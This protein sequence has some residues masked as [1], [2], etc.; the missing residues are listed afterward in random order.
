MRD[1][2]RVYLQRAGVFFDNPGRF[3]LRHQVYDFFE[4]DLLSIMRHA[5][6]LGLT[7]TNIHSATSASTSTSSLQ[8]LSSSS[9][10]TNPDWCGIET[11]R[12]MNIRNLDLCTHAI[13]ETVPTVVKGDEARQRLLSV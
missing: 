7:P 5:L 12:E 13:I 3:H 1:E 10:A 8:P 2:A 11:F 4:R 6:E 9:A